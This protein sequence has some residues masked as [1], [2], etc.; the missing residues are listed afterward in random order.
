MVAPG[1]DI[2]SFLI[3]RHFTVATERWTYDADD[4]SDDAG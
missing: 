2:L 3:A 4:G 1:H